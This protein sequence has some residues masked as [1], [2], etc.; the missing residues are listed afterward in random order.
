APYPVALVPDGAATDPLERVALEPLAAGEVVLERRLAGGSDGPAGLLEPGRRAVAVPVE[1]APPGVAAGDHVDAYAPA[2]ALSTDLASLRRDRA[3][4]RRVASSA[5]V[6][7]V[8]DRSAT[9]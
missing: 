6:V 8:D 9:V 4:A 3:G 7:S 2:V 5:L 1:A